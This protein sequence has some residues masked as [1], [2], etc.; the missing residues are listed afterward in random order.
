[1]LKGYLILIRFV[2]VIVIS[3]LASL[4]W[5]T[6]Y[7][8]C[9]AYLHTPK[10]SYPRI[11]HILCKTKKGNQLKICCYCRLRNIS[12]QQY[13]TPACTTKTLDFTTCGLL[14]SHT[15]TKIKVSGKSVHLCWLLSPWLS[16]VTTLG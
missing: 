6:L 2:A 7:T 16:M 14:T 9:A 15:S 4:F 3:I 10:I 11:L 13:S 1:M 12:F 8:Q 5:N